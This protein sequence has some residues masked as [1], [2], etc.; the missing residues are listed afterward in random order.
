MTLRIGIVGAGIMGEKVAVAAAALDGVTITAVADLDAA[1]ADA[2][3][4]TYDATSHPDLA[5]LLA[6][7]TTDA[8]YLG[9]PHHLHA[10]A[11]VAAL[12]AGI[13]VL[14]DKPLC[15]TRDEADAILAARDRSTAIAM[16]GFSYR[17]RAEWMRA[18]E[19]IA[20]GRIGTVRL[21]ADTIVEA[22]S[23]TPAW[24]WQAESGGG[25]LQLQSHH[26]FDRLRWLL[27][28]AF[29]SVSARTSTSA[30]AAAGNAED[31]AQVAAL[32]ASGALIGIELGFARGY[33]G[34][35]RA[36]TVIQGDLGHIVID[37]AARTAALFAS[38]GGD[39]LDA[40]DDDWMARE[41]ATFVAACRAARAVPPTADD[42]AAALGAALAARDSARA[43]GAWIEL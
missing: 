16:V 1:R 33:D 27:D 22:Q 6:A 31:T 21:V 13:H 29:V 9:L 28:D 12:D 38:D 5:A 30:S 26:C 41:I 37:S 42:G 40:T 4:A 17:F 43:N 20:S 7:G 23:R 8:I 39:T 10:D 14:I 19:W 3:A 36:T 34:P 35:S 15:N 2:L 25:V 18:Q 11:C 24:Y 32:T